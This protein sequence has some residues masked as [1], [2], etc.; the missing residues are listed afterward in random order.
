VTKTAAP[1]AGVRRVILIRPTQGWRAL[2]LG[3]IWEYRDLL[4]MLVAR[5]FKGRYRQM[6]LGPLWILLQPLVNMLVF[7]FVF[8]EVARLP[9][10][11][12]PY[13]IFTYVA[14]LPWQLFA[15]AVRTSSQSLLQ[16]QYVI[17]KV[18]F[19][20]LIAPIAS[21]LSACIDFAASLGVLALMMV[22]F[23]VPLRLE[24]LAY[25]PLC[26]LAALCA[27]GVGLWLAS[28]SVKYRDVALGVQFALPVWQALTPVAYAISLVPA[29]YLGLYRALNPVTPIIEASRWSML[30]TGLAPD[31]TLALSLVVSLGLVVTGAFYFRRTERNIVDLL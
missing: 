5:E 13:P 6:A 30:G 20:R 23:G 9:S 8:G 1:S 10:Q 2:Q 19:P 28:L 31:W 12:V 16:Q 11:G 17:S 26:A 7:S 25:L 15:T 24:M 27:L 21:V 4:A 22:L 29:G 18:Y 14:L 3:E